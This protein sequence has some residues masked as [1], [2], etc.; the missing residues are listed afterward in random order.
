MTEK[1]ARRI[2][3]K[4]YRDAHRDE[5]NARGGAYKF[6]GSGRAPGMAAIS[7]GTCGTNNK[8]DIY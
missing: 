1:D 4:L 7:R 3:D 2:E 6:I 8:I 5:I